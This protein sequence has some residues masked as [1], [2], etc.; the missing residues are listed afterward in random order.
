M[1]DR[2]TEVQY[3]AMSILYARISVCETRVECRG[4]F[5]TTVLIGLKNSIDTRSY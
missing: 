1:E 3:P 5:I 2:E 4:V